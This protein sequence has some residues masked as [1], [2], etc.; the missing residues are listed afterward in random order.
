MPKNDL[1]CI[2]CGAGLPTDEPAYKKSVNCSYCGQA[3]HNPNFNENTPVDISQTDKKGET[4]KKQKEVHQV[5]SV[6]QSNF[7]ILL[8]TSTAIA[9][10]VLYI[11]F[12]NNPQNTWIFLLTSVGMALPTISEYFSTARWKKVAMHESVQ[13]KERY[14]VEYVYQDGG[15]SWIACLFASYVF[16]VWF[17]FRFFS[18][19]IHGDDGMFSGTL[20][21]FLAMIGV[22]MFTKILEDV[23][24]F[25]GKIFSK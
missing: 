16:L 22:W 9:G 18:S 10:L 13:A 17:T 5:I 6:K 7:S 20:A 8:S 11:Y 12:W 14:Y 19:L 3:N 15:F 1:N 4:E 24:T 2:T 21:F 23:G 25:F